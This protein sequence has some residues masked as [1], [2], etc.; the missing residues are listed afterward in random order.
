MCSNSGHYVQ[1]TH[2][3]PFLS[4]CSTCDGSL[5]SINVMYAVYLVSAVMLNTINLQHRIR[6]DRLSLLV[7]GCH[8]TFNSNV[9]FTSFPLTPCENYDTKHR[10]S[11]EML[12]SEI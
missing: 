1:N 9:Q 10:R 7:A 11:R 8:N 6:A 12:L 3:L 4:Y 2:S 5:D